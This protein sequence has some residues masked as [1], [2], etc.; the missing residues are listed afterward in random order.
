MRETVEIAQ[1]LV[2]EKCVGMDLVQEKVR[3]VQ[4]HQTD[5]TLITQTLGLKTV[6]LL[7]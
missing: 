5:V 6:I 1:S 4:I 3:P 7:L 2:T